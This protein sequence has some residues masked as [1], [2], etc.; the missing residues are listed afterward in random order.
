MDQLT[1]F[2][3]RDFDTAKIRHHFLITAGDVIKQNTPDNPYDYFDGFV[4]KTEMMSE[5]QAKRLRKTSS[6]LSKFS[7][8]ECLDKIQK[9]VFDAL[10]K[11]DPSPESVTYLDIE[12]SSG[13]LKR[14]ISNKTLRTAQQEKVKA[15]AEAAQK[16][17]NKK[18]WE[19]GTPS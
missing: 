5:S 11:G 12:F 14:L 19:D 2:S 7:I 8:S 10:S 4:K 3:I 9:E 6:E 13:E 17:A 18:A 1:L 15:E 16:E